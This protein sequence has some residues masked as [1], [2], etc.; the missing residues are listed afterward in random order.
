M[1]VTSSG[2]YYFKDSYK[3]KIFNLK[4]LKIPTTFLI[5]LLFYPLQDVSVILVQL[6]IYIYICI[7]IYIKTQLKKG[8]FFPL[9]ANSVLLLCYL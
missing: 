9:L 6:K 5:I 8:F 4:I 1:Q 3:L 7:Y 2:L